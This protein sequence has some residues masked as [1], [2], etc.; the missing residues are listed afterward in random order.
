ML[1]L[2]TELCVFIR[3]TPTSAKKPLFP[4]QNHLPITLLSL[5][6]QLFKHTPVHIGQSSIDAILPESQ[7]FV[8]N[9]QKM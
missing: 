7:R 8:I 6:N 2:K 4:D 3:I 1:L 5:P 9:S